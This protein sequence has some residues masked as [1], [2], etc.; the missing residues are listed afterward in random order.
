MDQEIRAHLSSVP[1]TIIAIIFLTYI[2]IISYVHAIAKKNNRPLPQISFSSSHYYLIMLWVPLSYLILIL[3]CDIRYLIFFFASGIAGIVGETLLSI[4]WDILLDKPLWSYHH[5]SLLHRY[6]STINFLPW[7]T[8]GLIFLSVGNALA[9]DIAP[10]FPSALP[11]FVITLLSGFGGVMLAM[12]TAF[13]LKNHYTVGKQ[14]RNVPFSTLRFLIFCIPICTVFIALT[15][16]S[17]ITFLI[18]FF[19][20]AI[21]GNI[22]EY[23]YGKFISKIFNRRLWTYHDWKIDLDTQ[24]LSICHSGQ[25]VACIFI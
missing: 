23:M 4:V 9:I 14:W 16:I 22:L 25:L 21:F 6:T 3:C 24:V 13:I 19:A 17:N 1:I 10:P 12:I 2:G 5:G 7:T 8:G 11:Y 18:Y 20:F 15:M